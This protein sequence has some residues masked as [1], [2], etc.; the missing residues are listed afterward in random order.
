METP[1]GHI[2]TKEE[3]EQYSHMPKQSPTRIHSLEIACIV[4]ALQAN[5]S[6][7]HS[8]RRLMFTEQQIQ[9]V[10]KRHPLLYKQIPK[11]LWPHLVPYYE[12]HANKESWFKHYLDKIQKEMFFS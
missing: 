4:R 11:A 7:E 5:A 6:K 1:V 10:V 12:Y 3:F 9:N 2:M 8:Y